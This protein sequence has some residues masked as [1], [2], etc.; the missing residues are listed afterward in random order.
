MTKN[1]ERMK[2]YQ[3]LNRVKFI[4]KPFFCFL[5]SLNK[6][7]N[8]LF[9]LK[10]Y[11]DEIK[12]EKLEKLLFK[13]PELES[14]F[15][16]TVLLD[17]QW[18]NPNYWYRYSLIRKALGLSNCS[19][20]AVTGPFNTKRINKTLKTLNIN[21]FG[22]FESFFPDKEKIKIEV[23][24]FLKNIKT[25]SDLL[26]SKMPFDWPSSLVYDGILKH[27][28]NA[29]VDLKHPNFK[30][31]LF[32]AFSSI[33][34]AKKIIDETHPDLLLISH[35]I[36]FRYSALVWQCLLKNIPIIVLY[37]NHGSPSF[38]KINSIDDMYNW[39]DA[40]DLNDINSLDSTEYEFFH[41]A[42][43]QY[44]H[45]RFSGLT[46]DL[47]AIYSYGKRSV[48]RSKKDL[49]DYFGWD[50]GKKIVTV[51]T[52][53]WFDFPHAFGMSNFIDFK[54]WLDSTIEIAKE[55][56]NVLWL[57]KAHPIDQRYGGITLKDLMNNVSEDHIK[58]TP[59]DWNNNMIMNSVDAIIT[60]HGTSAIEFASKGIPVLIPDR[61]W[62]HDIGF[63][64][65]SRTREEYLD[66]LK[67]EW[68]EEFDIE[69]SKNL[70]KV[71]AGWHF[72]ITKW[73]EKIFMEDDSL[74]NELYDHL[75]DIFNSENKRSLNKEILTLRDWFYSNYRLYNTFKLRFHKNL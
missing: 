25:T 12:R 61:G 69:K 29:T 14:S 13:L 59:D 11:Q 47:G 44:L 66:Y 64:I 15:S 45:K 58:I 72:T 51:Y 70:A 42:G 74:Q 22:Q 49:L 68:W 5:V 63:C 67:T 16:G 32:E 60:Y 38:F 57:F 31:N 4:L 36:Q 27:Q 55:N 18:D 53:N 54:D 9:F 7:I 23:A 21:N 30:K 6:K 52:A 62:F 24:V 71:F 33:Y 17:A 10:N 65:W 40:P 20:V 73:Q 75:I 46:K 2:R 8:P 50:Q 34:A 41:N 1:F 3:I 19:E 26:N 37:G 35:A 39:M 48:I 43:E 56:S 28:T